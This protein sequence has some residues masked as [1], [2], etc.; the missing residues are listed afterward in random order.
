MAG[1]PRSEDMLLQQIP[2]PT[3]PTDQQVAQARRVVC[4][5]ADDAAEAESMLAMLGL[6]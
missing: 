6:L 4:S 3:K 5:Y 1:K 2:L